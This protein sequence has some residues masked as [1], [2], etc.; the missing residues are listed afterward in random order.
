MRRMRLLRGSVRLATALALALAA[1]PA[2][3]ASDAVADGPGD[4]IEA[5][6]GA[7][8]RRAR[9][10]AGVGRVAGVA[11]QRAVAEASSLADESRAPTVRVAAVSVQGGLD[12][13]FVLR[14]LRRQGA[15][16]E[17]RRCVAALPPAER[18]ATLELRWFDGGRGIPQGPAVVGASQPRLRRCVTEAIAGWRLPQPRCT[19]IIRVTLEVGGAA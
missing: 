13:Q 2:L 10:L 4:A 18:P 16:A 6:G 15:V 12:R 7:S 5:L 1:T 3:A 19:A 14:A 8:R 11:L 17:V 9:E